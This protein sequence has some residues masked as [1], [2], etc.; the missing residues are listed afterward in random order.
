MSTI[1]NYDSYIKITN[2]SDVNYINKPF[3]LKIVGGNSLLIVSEIDTASLLYSDITSPVSANIEALASTLIGYNNQIQKDFY[4]EISKGNVIGS[5]TITKFGLNSDVDT[6]TIPEDVW[7]VGGVNVQPTVARVHNI[8]STSASDTSA[9]IGA[10]TIL[11]RGIDDSFNAVSETIILNGTSNVSTVNS[12][13]HIHLMQVL[14]GGSTGAN[15][16]NILA[17][18]Q[19]DGTVTCQISIG[20]NQSA[21]S[22]Y[23]IPVGYKGYLIKCRARMGN[24]TANSE[25]TVGLYNKPFGGVFQLKTQMGLNNSGNSH[26]LLDYSH[27]AP[28]ILQGKS[29][30][31]LMCTNVSNNNTNITGEY[32]LILIAD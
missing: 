24:S 28:F 19:V 5:M 23:M 17:T 6:G 31:K 12:Y 8:N 7:D 20:I 10:R 29:M 32:D 9:G 11:I 13:V 3:D 22:L 1:V 25:S 30:T 18:A 14:T 15:A 16:G 4:L 2:G 21:S 26:V 27:S